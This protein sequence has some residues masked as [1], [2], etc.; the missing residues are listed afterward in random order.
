[1]KILQKLRELP[2]II[3]NGII[4][5][6]V[7]FTIGIFSPYIRDVLMPQPLQQAGPRITLPAEG[8]TVQTDAFSINL[9]HAAVQTTQEGNIV[10]TPNAI[11]VCL[12]HLQQAADEQTAAP[13]R[14][15]RLPTQMQESSATIREAACLFADSSAELKPTR[16]N[17]IVF[18]VALTG[19]LAGA[20]RDINGRISTYTDGAVS[21]LANSVTIPRG[22]HFIATAVLSFHGSWQVPMPLHL[23][24]KGKF[25]NADGSRTEVKMMKAEGDFRIATDPAGKWVA[26]ALFYRSSTEPALATKD[27]CALILIRPLTKQLSARPLAE[28]LQ[29]QDYNA[30]RQALALAP[31]TSATITLP[32]FSLHNHTQDLSAM[33]CALGAARLYSHTEA[34]FPGIAEASHFPLD[35]FYQQCELSFSECDPYPGAPS[36]THAPYTKLEFSGPFIW[37]LAPL[38]S[39]QAP[40]AMGVLENL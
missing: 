31:P 23:T 34:A 4:I 32:R 14:A 11:A 19:N 20:H 29:V 24:E 26:T 13:I 16:Q 36:P 1:M 18:P 38:T 10:I 7:A 30:I 15:L 2:P 17:S 21:H 28:Q 9:L 27:D 25:D 40:Y 5:T 35:A 6:A 39:S 22:Y 12:E 37:M 3:K 8:E 33:L